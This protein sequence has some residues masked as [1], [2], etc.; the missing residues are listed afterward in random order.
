M[1]FF[2][3]WGFSGRRMNSL[4]L[5][6]NLLEVVWLRDSIS[7]KERDRSSH[8]TRQMTA[9]LSVMTSSLVFFIAFYI[10]CV[11]RLIQ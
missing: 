7:I 4:Q 2:F 9:Q 3:S 8:S 10:Q 5:M 11:Y 1:I 6:S